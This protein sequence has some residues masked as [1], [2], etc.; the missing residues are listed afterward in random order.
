MTDYRILQMERDGFLE[1]DAPLYVCDR[2]G[3]DIY[4]GDRFL[5][6]TDDEYWCYDCVMESMRIMKDEG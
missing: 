4:D 6:I 3:G 2:C 5:P 1:D